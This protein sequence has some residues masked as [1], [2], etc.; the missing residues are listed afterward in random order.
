L[1]AGL[2][3]VSDFPRDCGAFVSLELLRLR[4]RVGLFSVGFASGDLVC[5][6]AA[7]FGPFS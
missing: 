1:D 2:L 3:F 6:D 5:D 4:D 7:A